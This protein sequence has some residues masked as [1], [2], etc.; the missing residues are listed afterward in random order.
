M[1]DLRK[2]FKRKKTMSINI[3]PPTADELSDQCFED[4][5]KANTD[6]DIMC[7]N[8]FNTMVEEFEEEKVRIDGPHER[9]I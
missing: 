6:P 5:I 9:N 2:I 7:E 8:A 4:M 1:I 3:E